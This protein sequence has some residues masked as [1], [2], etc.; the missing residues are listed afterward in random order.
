MMS[1]LFG[2]LPVFGDERKK[3][4]TLWCRERHVAFVLADAAVIIPPGGMLC[5]RGVTSDGVGL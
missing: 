1:V 4:W 2:C 3:S 5:G